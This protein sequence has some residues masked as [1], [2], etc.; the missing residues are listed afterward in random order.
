MIERILNWAVPMLCGSVLTGCI[1]WWKMQ[2][3]KN[4]ALE[5]GV[6]C[7]LRGEILRNYKEYSRKGY[8]PN[9]AK[10]AENRA[11]NA[12]HALGGNDIATDKHDM[13][14]KLP[15]EPEKKE[16]R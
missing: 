4:T 3:K 1:T 12:Y 5:D 10:E 7:L 14:M 15:D 11:Y 6:Q 9:Y 2:K 13:I 16:E 8:C